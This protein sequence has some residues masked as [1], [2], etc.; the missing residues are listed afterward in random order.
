MFGRF[1]ARA[2]GALILIL[3]VWGAI[4]PFIGPLF[5]YRVDT[6]GAWQ[7]STARAELN[8]GPGVIAILGGLLLMI[9]GYR[10]VQRFGAFIAGAAGTWFVVGALFYPLW[11]G[12]TVSPPTARVAG[13]S[14][15]WVHIVE[16]LGFFLGTGVLIALLAAYA[17]GALAS[18]G[19]AWQTAEQS[20][21]LRGAAR[22]APAAPSFPEEPV[23]PN[24]PVV[25]SR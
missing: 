24:P 5:G 6:M 3:G 25:A 4:A 23:G 11:T 19:R 13:L 22:T 17:Y 18:V 8:L 10:G 12:T 16:S 2:S 15:T 9:A 7:W 20:M 1:S 21:E 14:P